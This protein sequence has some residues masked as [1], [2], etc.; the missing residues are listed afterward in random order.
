MSDV[1]TLTAQ[2]CAQKTKFVF[3]T[4]HEFNEKIQAAVR[5]VIY[6]AVHSAIMDPEDHRD[7][8][9]VARDAVNA[10]IHEKQIPGKAIITTN[11]EANS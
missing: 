2:H 1:A 4:Q 5:L 10:Y 8:S 9:I 3:K 7:L 6:E 11:Q